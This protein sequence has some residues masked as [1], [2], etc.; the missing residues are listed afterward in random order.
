VRTEGTPAQTRNAAMV[1]TR[2]GRRA[3]LSIF[4]IY[5]IFIFASASASASVSVFVGKGDTL[6]PA[7]AMPQS[8]ASQYRCRGI[9]GPTG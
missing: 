8:T 3:D 6:A 4:M 5:I 9:A 1:R 7:E 2:T